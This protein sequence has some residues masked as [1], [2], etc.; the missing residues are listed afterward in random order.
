MQ[1]ESLQ[2]EFML[3]CPFFSTRRKKM[4][5][6]IVELLKRLHSLLVLTKKGYKG[7]ECS[8][9]CTCIIIPVSKNS[10]PAFF[11][12][13]FSRRLQGQNHKYRV[14]SFGNIWW[15]SSGGKKFDSLKNT[16]WYNLLTFQVTRE[17]V[18]V[19]LDH[20]SKI[21]RLSG[22]VFTGEEPTAKSSIPWN[23]TDC[24][25]ERPMRGEIFFFLF[26]GGKQFTV[27]WNLSF[28][29]SN[30]SSLDGA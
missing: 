6:F 26:G 18:N 11:L 25:R 16:A 30:Y 28:L 14:P 4:Y 24:V 13:R 7:E 20:Q 9:C 12:L 15:N 5:F 23:W 17:K 1:T 27:C 10:Q 29:A 8:N 22:P 3:S 19:S 21:F 2:L